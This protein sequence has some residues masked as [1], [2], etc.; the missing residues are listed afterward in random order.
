MIGLNTTTL[1]AARLLIVPG[2]KFTVA[3][4]EYIKSSVS[5][6]LRVVWAVKVTGLL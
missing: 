6:G 3:N 4:A 2:V 1:E 5:V